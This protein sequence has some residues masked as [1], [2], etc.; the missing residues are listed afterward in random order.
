MGSLELESAI[1][2]LRH[3]YRHYTK[4]KKGEVL[5]E[6]KTR[7]LVDKKYLIRLLARKAGGRPKTRKKLGRPSK[8]DEP[9]FVKNLVTLWDTAKRICPRYLKKAIPEWVSSLEELDG[10]YAPEIKEKLLKISASTI[11]RVLRKVRAIKG[12]SSTRAGNLLRHQ[13]PIQGNIW[14]IS[15]P[16]FIECD[17]VAHCGGSLRGDF[18]YSLVTTDI[19]ST[20]TECRAVYGRGSS[21]VLE[22]LKCIETN[23]PF[24]LLGYDSDNGGEVLNKHII[25]HFQDREHPVR[26]TRSRAY[27]KDDNAHVEQKNNS[28]VRKYLG[29]ERLDFYQI[30]PLINRYYKEVLCPLLNHFIPTNKLSEKLYVGNK[31]KRIYAPPMTPYE[32]LITSPQLSREQRE[33]LVAEHRALNP[34]SLS[35]AEFRLRNTID[36]ELRNLKLSRSNIG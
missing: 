16:G 17:T 8:Y 26:V 33:K 23:L 1:S 2:L 18:V 24:S 29:Y 25:A 20:W 4:K 22:Q 12:I 35:R 9:L 27:K 10:S 5:E 19:A 30:V 28:T 3:R 14:D 32:R 34:V 11:N 7:F 21:G 13:I 6:L 31:L 15:V 36:A